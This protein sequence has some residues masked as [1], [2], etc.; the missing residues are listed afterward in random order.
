MDFRVGIG[1]DVHRLESGDYLIL[2]GVKIPHDKKFVGHSDGDALIH[3]ICDAL[4]GAAGLKD[5]GSHFQDTNPDYKGKQSSYF[6]LETM[7]MVREKGYEI[8]NIDSSIHLQKPKLQPFMDEIRDNLAKILGIDADRVSVKA[9][10]GERIGFV[11]LEEG[12][13]VHSVALICK[14]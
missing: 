7:K 8:S 11:G 1:T 13:E 10:T 12:V 5:I 9:K 3:S 14:K 4:L 6:L 2:G